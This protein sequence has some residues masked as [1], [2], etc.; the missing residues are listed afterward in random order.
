[1]PKQPDIV[2][3]SV[4]FVETLFQERLP[5]FLVYHTVGHSKRVANTA[6]KIAKKMHLGEEGIEVVTLAGWFH[7]AGYT[8]LYRGHEEVSVR[9]AKEFLEI[10]GYPEEK[11][12]LIAGCIRAT[13]IPQQPQNL[14]EE[15]VADAD[16]A[17]LGRK[18]FFHDSELLHF[19]WEEEFHK[20][21][22]EQEWT[23]NNINLLSGH[24]FFTRYAKE[25]YGNRQL[26]NLHKLQK[27]LHSIIA[28]EEVIVEKQGDNIRKIPYPA[29]SYPEYRSEEEFEN[30]SNAYT[31]QAVAADQKANMM[32]VANAV[33]IGICIISIVIFRYRGFLH[34][35]AMIPI[36]FLLCNSVTS[37]FFSALAAR[38]NISGEAFETGMNHRK[39]LATKYKY[40]NRSYT[41]F[42]YG[43]GFSFASFILLC[44]FRMIF[45]AI[46]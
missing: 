15:I 26:T 1:M 18:S 17:G 30:I 36:L 41:V 39:I 33:M 19:E 7:D 16:L 42:I 2:A 35:R 21:Y 4:A 23:E 32:I 10:E 25:K 27:R 22:S 20:T 37:I 45:C 5:E 29:V 34:I 12:K 8:E 9:I 11:I 13:K 40:L 44:L 38:S 3:K 14:L 24:T 28:N 46:Q 31:T 6:Q 43:L